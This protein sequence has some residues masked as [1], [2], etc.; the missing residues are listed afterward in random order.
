[1]VKNK[2]DCA[3]SPR[4]TTT[5]PTYIL[6]PHQK[7]TTIAHRRTWR[8][9]VGK[10]NLFTRTGR[11]LRFRRFIYLKSKHI[12]L[13]CSTKQTLSNAF[14]SLNIIYILLLLCIIVYTYTIQWRHELYIHKG[15][16]YYETTHPP[17]NQI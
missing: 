2:Q 1:M 12:Q 15:K 6:F 14:T 9:H 4:Y 5:V 16:R 10:V 17:T 13:M 3:R 8:S 11:Y 7:A